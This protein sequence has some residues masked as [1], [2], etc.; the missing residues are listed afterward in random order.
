METVTQRKQQRRP[1]KEIIAARVREIANVLLDGAVPGLDVVDFIRQ[2]ETE[3]DSPFFLG[4]DRQPLS[5]SQCRKIIKQ[6]QRLISD[7]VKEDRQN[8]I[9][10]HLARLRNLYAKAVAIADYRCA[11]S[12]LQDEAQLCGLYPAKRTEHTGA[13]GQA[14]PSLSAMVF[15]IIQAE[16]KNGEQPVDSGDASDE[17]RIAGAIER[18]TKVP[19]EPVPLRDE[20][21]QDSCQQ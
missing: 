19:Q 5:Y 20:L 18:S 13:N 10:L 14:L 15:A 9:D 3:T 21:L 17:R 1:G 8:L 4:D 6:A 16:S 11:L 12:I 2:R 7:T